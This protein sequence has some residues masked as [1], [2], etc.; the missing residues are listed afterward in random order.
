MVRK[1]ILPLTRIHEPMEV[2]VEVN[3]GQVTDAWVSSTLFRGFELM[4]ENRDPRDTAIYS[5]RICG[6]CSTAHAIAGTLALE[7]AYK[8]D[9]TPNGFLIR[10]L[11]VG[12]DFLQNHLRQFYLLALPDYAR[13]PDTAPFR[14]LLKGDYRIPEKLEKSMY[15]N[16]WKATELSA[17]AHQMVAIWGAK[18]PHQQTIIPGGITEK[19]DAEKINMFTSILRDIEEFVLDK[20][21]PDVQTIA[22]Y[23]PEYYE[24]GKGYGNLMSFGMFPLAKNK[25]RHFKPGYIENFSHQEVK[26]IDYQLIKEEVAKSWYKESTEAR[27]PY[28]EKTIPDKGK[29][30]AYSWIKTPQ[31]QGKPFEG[32]P[33]ARMWLNSIYQKGISVNDRNIARALELR[34]IIKEMYIWLQKIHLSQPSFNKYEMKSQ[35]QGAGLVDSMRGQLGHWVKIED[36]RTAHYQVITPSAWNFAPRDSQNRRGPV[37]EALIGTPVENL[38]SLIEVG[39]VIRCFDPCFSCSVHVVEGERRIRK[40]QL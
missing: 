30:G 2:E 24:I 39:R 28:E 15:E 16:F 25:P 19:P 34:E 29:A 6:I 22:E 14:P 1:K 5:Q 38:E 9:P 32:G 8:V 11:I 31:Y 4:L 13:G 10:N 23:Y 27:H 12:A 18:A 7:E 36:G 20:Y 35:G 40:Y 33:L 3:N 37:E 21:I 26:E 17:K